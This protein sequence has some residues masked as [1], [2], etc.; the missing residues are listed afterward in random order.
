MPPSANIFRLTAAPLSLLSALPVALYITRQRDRLGKQAVSLSPPSK[1][2]LRPYFDPI[3]LER[4]RIVESDPLPIPDLPLSNQVRRLGLDFLRPSL[5][6][7]ITLDHVIA[8]RVPMNARLLFHELVHV[9]QFR[10][11]GVLNFARLY[12]RGFFTTGSYHKIPLERCAL[13]LERRFELNPAPFNVE[14][15]V[16]TW[17]KGGR[18]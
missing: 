18:F 16:R 2:Q 1:R 15:E 11:L 5:I 9:V 4:V 12:T 14:A 6:A 13:D 17:I 8:S 7:A 10:L 3:D